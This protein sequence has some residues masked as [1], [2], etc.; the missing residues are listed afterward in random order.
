MKAPFSLSYLFAIVLL[1]LAAAV[2]SYL[3]PSD[4]ANLTALLLGV[5]ALHLVG[6]RMQMR[7]F[8]SGGFMVERAKAEQL[9]EIESQREQL[10]VERQVIEERERVLHEKIAAAEEQWTL[11]RRMVRERVERPSGVSDAIG[12]G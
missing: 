10:Q 5:Y 4:A 8:F 1:A 12:T 2:L 3:F 9:A 6:L 11:F 7:R